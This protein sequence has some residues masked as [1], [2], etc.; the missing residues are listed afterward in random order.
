[1]LVEIEL[2]IHILQPRGNFEDLFYI[3]AP[4][5]RL[6]LKCRAYICMERLGISMD[7]NTV[8]ILEE[9]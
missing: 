2:Q 6:H 5:I 7:E 8:L 4:L 1:M 9:L 3:K